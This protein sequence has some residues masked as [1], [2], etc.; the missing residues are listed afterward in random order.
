[1][2][3]Q[4]AGCDLITVQSKIA[5][6][7]LSVDL[8][9]KDK[10]ST[11][12]NINV[13]DAFGKISGF[14]W[15][16]L[17]LAIQYYYFKLLGTHQPICRM[18]YF[19]DDDLLK[20]RPYI[21]NCFNSLTLSKIETVLPPYK[22]WQVK[23]NGIS[24]FGIEVINK[25]SSNDDFSIMLHELYIDDKAYSPLNEEDGLYKCLHSSEQKHCDADSTIQ[26]LLA[27]VFLK[28]IDVT[29]FANP[30][31]EGSETLNKIVEVKGDVYIYIDDFSSDV[32]IKTLCWL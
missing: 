24:D 14:P 12:F 3:V 29:S 32:K 10:S 2:I 16:L 13:V 5:I 20:L 25:V 7:I 19:S 11:N 27:N 22:L 28:S 30:R 21:Q 26:D 9:S 31:I 15:I 23:V 18:M 1:M 6:P 4:K 17:E 8:V